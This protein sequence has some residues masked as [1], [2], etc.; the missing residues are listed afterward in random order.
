MKRIREVGI[1]D[2]VG[3]RQEDGVPD[4]LVVAVQDPGRTEHAIGLVEEGREGRGDLA[5]GRQLGVLR[6]EQVEVHDPAAGECQGGDVLFPPFTHPDA[7]VGDAVRAVPGA[8][9]AS[10]RDPGQHCD[11]GRRRLERAVA[12]EDGVVEVRR[13]D[14]GA[15]AADCRAPAL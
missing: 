7:R 13:D 3:T 2:R 11:D 14:D 5:R 8:G 12:G 9:L 6:V 10:R 4:D 1:E 15:H